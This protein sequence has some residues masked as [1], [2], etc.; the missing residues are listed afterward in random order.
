M[1]EH[2]PAII[3]SPEALDDIDRLWDYYIRAAGRVTA[4]K[5][6]REVAKAVAVIDGFPLAGRTRA[7]LRSLAAAPQIVFYRLKD[8]RPE[9]VRVLDGRQDIEE[10][11]SA[12][13]NG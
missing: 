12:D 10:I 6:L 9:I 7:G 5:V 13:E 1:A 8:D 3:W 11:F 4:D 2:K